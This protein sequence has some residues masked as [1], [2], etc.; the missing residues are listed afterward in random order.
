ML[1]NFNLEDETGQLSSALSR[2]MLSGIDLEDGTGQRSS[3]HRV[4]MI[5][6]DLEAETF[7]LKTQRAICP[8]HSRVMLMCF[9]I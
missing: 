5:D 1:R 9:L 2:F 4:M 7:N 6:F 8:A 3:A